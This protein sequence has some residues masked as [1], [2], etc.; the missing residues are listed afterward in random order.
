MLLITLS[1]LLMDLQLWKLRCLKCQQLRRKNPVEG[2]QHR[3]SP[4]PL[5]QKFLMMMKMTNI[6]R[7]KEVAVLDAKKKGRRKPTAYAKE[8]AA[9]PLL[10]LQTTREE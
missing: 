7:L 4:W 1:L 8:A 9:K 2:L 3:K 5:S 6:L 10:L